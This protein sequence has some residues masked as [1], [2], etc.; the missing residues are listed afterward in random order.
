MA[1]TINGTG[2]ITGISAGGLPDNC[3]TADDLATTLD[4]SG[5]TLTLPAIE[6]T[7]LQTVQHTSTDQISGTLGTTSS[8]APTS[9]S[10]TQF[11][12]FNFT[13]QSADS[14]ILLMSST[15]AIGETSNTADVMWAGAWAGTSR[16]IVNHTGLSYA[17][18]AGNLNSA[19]LTLVGQ[20]SSWGTSQRTISIRVGVAGG[21][22]GSK[23]VNQDETANSESNGARDVKFIMMEIA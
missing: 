5:S 6:G 20:I 17:R 11:T 16:I 10:G 15:I 19:W 1:I 9:T 2:T 21:N 4:L 14:T 3:V 8:A 13:P 12:S 18:F 22:G 23:A 7:I